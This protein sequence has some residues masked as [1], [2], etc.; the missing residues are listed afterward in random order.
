MKTLLVVLLTALGS[1]V[2]KAQVHL[3]VVDP[4]LDTKVLEGK[5]IAIHQP[6]VGGSMVPAKNKREAF[7]ARFP[8]ALPH[9][10]SWDELDRDLFWFHLK[11]KQ[12]AELKR[13]YQSVPAKVLEDMQKAAHD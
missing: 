11:S 2:V 9:M 8:A 5:P 13:R 4:A 1:F 10:Q 7:F 12:L 3:Q 6:K